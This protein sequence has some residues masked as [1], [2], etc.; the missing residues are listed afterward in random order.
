MAQNRAPESFAELE[1]PAFTD[2]LPDLVAALRGAAD[3]L[4]ASPSS[5]QSYLPYWEDVYAVAHSLKGVLGLLGCPEDLANFILSL[6]ELLSDGLAGP[7]VC[8]RLGAAAEEL[9]KVARVLDAKS[10]DPAALAAWTAHFPSLYEA[11]LSHEERLK[12]VP[13]KLVYVDEKVS[14]RAR[15][16]NRLGLHQCALEDQILLDQIPAWRNRLTATLLGED[17]S[18]GLVVNFLPFLSAEG[19]RSLRVWAWVAAATP[20]R[21]ALKQRLKE[22]MP[23]AKILSL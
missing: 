4:R 21:A 11:D 16:V 20:S 15:E 17:G 2:R 7:S 13:P 5:R 1:L 23:N 22:A 18:R 14:K 8:G 10:P 19:S 9:A 12:A 3:S 6:N